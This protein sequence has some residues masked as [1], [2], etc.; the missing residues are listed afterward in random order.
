MRS[1]IGA[2]LVSLALAATNAACE[3]DATPSATATAKSG[4]AEERAC[5]DCHAE[6]A[7]ASTASLHGRARSDPS[8]VLAPARELDKGFCERCHDPKGDG[9]GVGCA[10]C[11]ATFHGKTRAASTQTAAASCAPCHEFAFPARADAMQLTFTEHALSPHRDTQCP[12]CHMKRDGNRPAS[13]GFAA[14]RD[15]KMLARAVVVTGQREA[16]GAVTVSLSQ[17]D[18]GHASPTGDLFRQLRVVVERIS[19]T[20]ERLD[21]ADAVVGRTFGLAHGKKGQ[22]ADNRPGSPANP[23]GPRTLL[24]L[25]L[26]HG[27]EETGT[28]VRY[29]VSYE[30]V[31]E[32]LS[33]SALVEES[34]L[35]SEGFIP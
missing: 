1:P 9:A 19:G 26:P 4:A 33:G 2:L 13:H 6:I 25:A 22:T 34:M 35:V 21:F 18:V 30:R 24:R 11:H 28:V 8:Y 31:A 20:G 10:F 3:R 27:S 5:G 16:E 15:P 17:G 7:R 32:A 14:S 23:G 12:T 29:R